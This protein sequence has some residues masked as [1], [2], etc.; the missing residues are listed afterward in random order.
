MAWFLRVRGV[1]PR[2]GGNPCEVSRDCF[3]D[4]VAKENGHNVGNS[5]GFLDSED[6]LDPSIKLFRGAVIGCLGPVDLVIL[7]R[8]GSGDGSSVGWKSVKQPLLE[9]RKL[10]T[11][12]IGTNVWKVRDSMLSSERA[13]SIRSALSEFV[14]QIGSPPIAFTVMLV[15]KVAWAAIQEVRHMV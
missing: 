15:G 7:D 1:E 2:V 6:G 4:L 9:S 8:F 13:R 11:D 10:G 12:V 14:Q 3:G 5:V